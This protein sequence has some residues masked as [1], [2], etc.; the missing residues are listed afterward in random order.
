MMNMVSDTLEVAW[1]SIQINI[2]KNRLRIQI[3]L[4]AT[5][6]VYCVGMRLSLPLWQSDPGALATRTDSHP[7][8]FAQSGLRRAERRHAL[9]PRAGEERD[10]DGRDGNGR[11]DRR[12]L[13]T[14]P[15]LPLRVGA[16]LWA[17]FRLWRGWPFAPR[18]C[19]PA[20]RPLRAPP[21]PRQQ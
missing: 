14:W 20:I 19:E 18:R 6:R 10:L 8:A 1:R 11:A 21:F 5:R 9:H 7:G 12:R 13:S 4:T 15:N 17:E 16:R 3:F 2:M